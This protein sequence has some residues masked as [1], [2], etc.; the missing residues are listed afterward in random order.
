MNFTFQYPEVQVRKL[1]P[2]RDEAA[3]ISALLVWVAFLFIVFVLLYACF[4]LTKKSGNRNVNNTANNA[5]AP[6]PNG[7]LP[8]QALQEEGEDIPM[9][10]IAPNANE[11]VDP[12]AAAPEAAPEAAPAPAEQQK[13]DTEDTERA[14][15]EERREQ[16]K[17]ELLA[18][19]CMF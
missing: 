7:N 11:Q 6:A 19:A 15:E 9:Q 12:P 2:N 13:Q 8:Y 18:A 1:T 10:N 17:E 16:E 3:G 5:N 14:K 4:I